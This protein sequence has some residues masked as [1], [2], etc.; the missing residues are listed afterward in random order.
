MKTLKVFVTMFLLVAFIIGCGGDKSNKIMKSNGNEDI[1]V[2]TADFPLE[3]PVSAIR[4]DVPAGADPSV[5]AE[6]GGEGFTGEGWETNKDYELFADPNAKKGGTFISSFSE[7]PP[8]FRDVG[9]DSNREVLSSINELVYESL[10]DIDYTNLNYTPKLASHWKFSDDKKTFWFRIDPNARW[11]DGKRVTADDI[12]ASWKLRIDEGILA[13]YSNNL[14]RKYK[15][16]KVSTYI[17]KASVDEVNWRLFLYFGGMNIFP[18]H[19]LDKINGKMYLEKYQYKMLPGT[20]PYILDEGNTIKGQTISLRR[21]SDWWAASN[22]HNKGLYNFDEIRFNIIKEDVLEKEKFKKGELDYYEV[23]N[24]SWWVREFDVKD[25]E[26]SYDPLTRGLVQ[27]RKVFNFHPEGVSGLVFNMREAPFNDVRVRKALAMLFNRKLI[28]EK[29]FFNEYES[30]YSSYPNS[31]YQNKNNPRFDYNPEKANQL[32]DEAGWSKRN[33]EG[34]RLNENGEPFEITLTIHQRYEQ[35]FTILQED[36]RKAGIVLN[37]KLA[38][39]NSLFQMGLERRFKIHYQSWTALF[40]PNPESSVHS[41]LADPDNT[42]NFAGVKNDRIDEICAGYNS[43]F[44]QKERIRAIQEVDSILAETVHYAY[45]WYRPYAARFLYWNKFGMPEHYVGY[46]GNWR[47]PLRY[48]WYEPELAEKLEKAKTDE[49]IT[50]PIGETNVD[51]WGVK[52][53]NL[54]Y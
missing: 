33:D 35:R 6:Q 47:Y 28:N 11:S 8:T 32:L 36:L 13:P 52:K 24:N 37:I 27:K 34:V 10:I 43:M 17:V 38:D 7:Y 14:Y 54:S 51:Y 44:D 45:A 12:V 3:G 22:P 4:Y 42:N 41:S 46:V 20:G 50:F 31:V 53:N 29:L 18:A 23:A 48:W 19:H 40:F 2:A 26:P 1:L 16:E 15:V 21:R 39:S 5:S 49:S 25:P 9:K 30:L